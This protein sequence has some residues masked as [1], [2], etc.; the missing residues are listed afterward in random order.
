MPFP[1]LIMSHGDPQVAGGSHVNPEFEVYEVGS[2]PSNGMIFKH[3]YL[4]PQKGL[5]WHKMTRDMQI[6][7]FDLS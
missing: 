7:K 5:K 6:L 2:T 1:C 4:E 3:F